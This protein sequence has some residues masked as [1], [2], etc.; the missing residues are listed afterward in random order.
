M[1]VT[2]G[3]CDARPTV[4]FP[5]AR[6]HRPLAGTKL[7]CLVTKGTCVLNNLPR[8]A[9]ESG[10]AGIR[11]CDILIASPARYRYTTEPHSLNGLKSGHVHYAR[12][13]STWTGYRMHVHTQILTCVFFDGQHALGKVP[14]RPLQKNWRDS[15]KNQ[16][17]WYISFFRVRVLFPMF[18]L[19]VEGEC[20]I[21][22]F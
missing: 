21:L 20:Q 19:L 22:V 18:C 5:A 16:I 1:S 3:Q 11:T 8:V 4:A 10:A 6:H 7:Y 14:Q 9:L 13:N 15:W 12:C 17:Y 2:R